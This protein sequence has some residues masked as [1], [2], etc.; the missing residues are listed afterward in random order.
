M[1][2]LAPGLKLDWKEDGKSTACCFFRPLLALLYTMGSKKTKLITHVEFE[3]FLT[4]S[5]LCVENL[6]WRRFKDG[7]VR[8]PRNLFFFVFASHL[9]RQ[10][11]LGVISSTFFAYWWV[12]K[13]K[14]CLLMNG[15]DS[16]V[17]LR[18]LFANV[19][20]K[21]P[22]LKHC[23]SPHWYDFSIKDSDFVNRIRH[24]ENMDW[25]LIAWII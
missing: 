6:Q 8:N 17:K 13:T 20:K 9:V 5:A 15:D 22:Y 11:A 19:F 7:L 18:K 21:V 12:Q 23:V 3:F 14:L 10:D 16:P 25:F 4:L 1:N 24:W 2:K